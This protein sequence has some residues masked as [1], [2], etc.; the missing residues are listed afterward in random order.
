[1]TNELTLHLSALRGAAA[2]VNSV[3]DD[4]NGI[5]KKIENIL[6]TEMGIAIAAHSRT[7]FRETRYDERDTETSELIQYRHDDY[8]SYGRVGGNYCIHIKTLTM[9]YIKG[10][11]RLGSEPSTR[12]AWSECDR[13]TRLKAFE[14]L[15]G[16]L[17][18]IIRETEKLSELA[19]ETA[20]KVA[21]MAFE[22][23]VDGSA[24]RFP[25][26]P[27][28][29]CENNGIYMMIVP[30]VTVDGDQSRQDGSFWCFVFDRAGL[31][32]PTRPWALRPILDADKHPRRFASWEEAVK[33]GTEH[34]ELWLNGKI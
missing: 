14:G 28:N 6:I 18:S 25:G 34:G 27:G 29:I 3:V 13:E 10:K 16:L 17:V 26:V 2:R 33:D 32:R 8:L 30:V 23:E 21:E 24:N 11:W 22:N 1:M 9:Q 19:S 31:S 5:V 7:A 20:K 4:V 15:P 12:I